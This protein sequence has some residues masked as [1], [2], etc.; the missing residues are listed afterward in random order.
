MKK[1]VLMYAVAGHIPN[2]IAGEYIL[3]NSSQQQQQQ[4]QQSLIIVLLICS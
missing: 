1:L 2:N 4:Q 3:Q